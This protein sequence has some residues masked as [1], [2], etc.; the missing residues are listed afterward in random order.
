MSSESGI[1]LT[2]GVDTTRKALC[3]PIER[4][5]FEDDIERRIIIVPREEFFSDPEGHSLIK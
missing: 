1:Y 4:N 5:G 3:E 2:I